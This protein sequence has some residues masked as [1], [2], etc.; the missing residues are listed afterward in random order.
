MA[1]L[2]AY[3]CVVGGA[4][5]PRLLCLSLGGRHRGDAY[6]YDSPA[7][8]QGHR[9]L[10]VSQWFPY[11]LPSRVAE[12]KWSGLEELYSDGFFSRWEVEA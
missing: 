8:D 9:R 3:G 7:V 11:V 1:A 6:F 10:T 5:A 12:C 4:Y 2:R